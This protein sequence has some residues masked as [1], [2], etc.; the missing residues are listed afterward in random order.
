MRVR[1]TAGSSSTTSIGARAG[2]KGAITRLSILSRVV[3]RLQER[4]SS[5]T[6]S[7]RGAELSIAGI[8]KSRHDVAN[9]VEPFIDSGHVDGYVRVCLA[10][11]F[12]ALWR[13]EQPDVLDSFAA[14][15]LQDVDARLG[16]SAGRQHRVEHDRQLHPVRRRQPVV[17]L[18]RVEGTLVAVQADMPHLGGG[19]HL[20]ETFDH[21][22]PGAQ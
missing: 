12:D 3:E 11:A 21:T 6:L 13:G 19:D 7:L 14:P 20:E 8:A 5:V 15:A 9:V 2:R 1:V 16:G 4:E 18:D 10:Q 22:Q 17:V